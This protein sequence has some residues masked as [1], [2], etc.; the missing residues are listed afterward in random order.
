MK[1]RDRCGG[2]LGRH[3]LQMAGA[4]KSGAETQTPSSHEQLLGRR[5]SRP[6]P[7]IIAWHPNTGIAI[8]VGTF[9]VPRL[10]ALPPPGKTCGGL[11]T[12]P[13][14]CLCPERD[15]SSHGASVSLH[16]LHPSVA[17]A[18]S[19]WLSR[20][21]GILVTAVPAV[22]AREAEPACFW[23]PYMNH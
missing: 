19:E 7:P 6:T 10:P 2:A 11:G 23:L 12:T 21:R 22:P 1:V 4:G 20:P 3:R 14:R 16:H 8:P 13:G 17:R 5:W 9:R 18:R 15:H